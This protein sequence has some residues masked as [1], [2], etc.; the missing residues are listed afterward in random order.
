MEDSSCLGE[1][2]K[3][4]FLQVNINLDGTMAFRY[5][6]DV[7]VKV[8]S[9]VAT[10]TRL[11]GQIRMLESQVTE[12]AKHHAVKNQLREVMLREVLMQSEP[13]GKAN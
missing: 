10:M 3:G 1:A 12:W 7:G 4:V 5:N 8:I 6:S 13:E 11:V 2:P 9:S